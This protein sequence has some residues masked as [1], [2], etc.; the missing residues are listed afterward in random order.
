MALQREARAN[1]PSLQ[2]CIRRINTILENVRSQATSESF[3]ANTVRSSLS[4]LRRN[5]QRLE[6]AGVDVS[7]LFECLESLTTNFPDPTNP[8]VQDT[9]PCISDDNSKFTMFTVNKYLI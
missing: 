7:D 1:L 6:S 4:D 3:D 2:N 9:Q 5:L 8:D